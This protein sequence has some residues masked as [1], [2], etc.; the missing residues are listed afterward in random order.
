MERIIIIEAKDGFN[1]DDIRGKSNLIQ[2]SNV[3]RLRIKI[4]KVDNKK[5]IK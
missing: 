2:R 1:T 5:P 3:I 4:V